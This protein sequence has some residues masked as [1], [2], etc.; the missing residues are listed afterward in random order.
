MRGNNEE[1]ESSAFV[2]FAE[3][4]LSKEYL[5]VRAVLIAVLLDV[6]PA[7]LVAIGVGESKLDARNEF[8]KEEVKL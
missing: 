6:S 3:K 5:L 4:I 2:T 1:V 8:V 7:F